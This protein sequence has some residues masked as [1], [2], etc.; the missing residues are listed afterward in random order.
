VQLG[1]FRNS[2][3]KLQLGC[4]PTSNNLE[5]HAVMVH[6]ITHLLQ[7]QFLGVILITVYNLISGCGYD[8]RVLWTALVYLSSLFL[9][10]LNFY[11]KSYTARPTAA[12]VA[13]KEAD[14]SP[15]VG[16][17]DIEVV[18]TGKVPGDV[19]GRKIWLRSSAKKL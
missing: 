10:F 6:S 16:N 18:K 7:V 17:R 1:V 9:L 2:V 3:H 13:R 8:R 14:T 15:A 5:I 12:V 4:E 19:G 11:R